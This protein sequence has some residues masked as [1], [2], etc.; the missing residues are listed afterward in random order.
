MDELDMWLGWGNKECIRNFGEETSWYKSAY[1]NE[2]DDD[3]AI[4]LRQI[5]RK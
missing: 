1:K 2:R 5:V 3:E 4:T